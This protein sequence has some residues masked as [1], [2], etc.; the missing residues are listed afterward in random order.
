[1]RAMTLK[2]LYVDALSRFGPQPLLH[3]R[4]RT[5]TY[6]EI[7]ADA[8]RLAN[9]LRAQGVGPGVPVAI[10]TSNCPEFVVA[11]QAVLRCGAVKVA[12]N[13]MLSAKEIEYILRDSRA[14]V[15]IADRGMLPAALAAEDNSLR[16]VIAAG[17]APEAPEEVLAWSDALA[18]QPDC[19][20]DGDPSPDDLG[21]IIYTGG[22]TGLPK[23]VMHSQS[24]LVLNLL[25][26]V[27]EMGVL[28][29]EV[30][31]LMS[32][33]PHS[34]GF[35]LA[36][37]M[38]KGARC[39]LETKFDPELVIER[40]TKDRVT[41]TF[42]VPTMI[43][44][45]LDR[46]AGREMDLSSLRTILYGAAP[47]TRERLA[48]GLAVFGPVFMQLYGQSEAPNFVTRLPREDHRL[49][50]DGSQRL[51]S[52]GRAATMAQVMVVDDEDRPVPVGQVGEIVART[53]Y[54]MLGYLGREEQT[55]KTLRGGW[56]H[57]GDVGRMDAEGYVYLMDRKN[58]MIITGGMNVYSTEVE[59]AVQVC[60]GVAQV[61]VVGVPHPDWGEAVVA[62]VVP[63]ASGAF[64]EDKLIA[65]CRVELARYKQPKAVKVVESL[66][67]T[68]YGKLDKKAL[69]ASWPG[70]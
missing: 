49:E 53:P 66:P 42:M 60:P 20:P 61:A 10:M 6:A 14:E 63:D 51:A 13:D 70:W 62:F 67:T 36:A 58:D 69:R 12:L 16:L 5:Y 8:N 55:A 24:N 65:H 46:A 33:L 7:V 29:D 56:L 57:T 40:I 35:L 48:Q 68:A 41:Y 37:S 19:V 47:I 54:N 26:H 50:G 64:D 30:L 9:R 39:H 3:F 34:A 1:M 22:T 25:A 32:P 38:L 44:R 2:S 31:L 59:N 4:G 18:G 28:D 52:C 17:E 11:D 23:G 27:I 21:L 45:V 15:A 43:Y